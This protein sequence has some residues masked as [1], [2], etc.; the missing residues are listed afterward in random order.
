LLLLATAVIAVSTGS[1]STD[2]LWNIGGLVV[3]VVLIACLVHQ[4]LR[5]SARLLPQNALRLNSPLLALY[6]TIGLLIIGMTSETFV[7][8]FLQ[9]LHGH[10]PLVSGYMVALIAAGWTVAEIWSSGWKDGA[11]R[12][13]II[14]GP[15]LV[16]IGMLL[17]AFSMPI[18]SQ[19]D[20]LMLALISLGLTLIGL[21]IG[22]GWP[23]LLTRVLQLAANGDQDTAASSITTVQLFATALG[24][25]MAGMLANM[26]GLNAPGGLAGTSNAAWWVFILLA[27]A[28]LLAIFSA[29]RVTKELK[30]S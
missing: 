27:A 21:G 15:V 20:G 10:S 4:E 30:N 9:I 13:A 25:A 1:T 23:H 14:Y 6:A 3:A 2:L 16:W 12:R 26:G 22:L 28:P 19:G 7:P 11:V 8:Y 24:S 17:M 18:Q 29:V 5:G